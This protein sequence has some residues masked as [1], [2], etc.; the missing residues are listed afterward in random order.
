MGPVETTPAGGVPWRSPWA[1]S[2]HEV[3]EALGLLGAQL[4]QIA[5][6]P[7]RS[8][9]DLTPG[10]HYAL[11]VRAASL[12]TTGRAPTAPLTDDTLPP[13]ID[14]VVKVMALAEYLM[15]G[16]RTPDQVAAL[17]GGVRAW[18]VW[19]IGAEQRLVFRALD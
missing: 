15:N 9:G 6:R 13:D 10:E 4:E 14:S 12:W 3:D 8:V 7:G 5:A 16:E 2:P 19:L 17:A 1:R 18:L 11:G